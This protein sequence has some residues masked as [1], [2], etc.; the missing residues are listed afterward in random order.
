MKVKLAVKAQTLKLCPRGSDN[1]GL[2]QT[3]T[4]KAVKVQVTHLY[5]IR[6][7][8]VEVNL[9]EMTDLKSKGPLNLFQL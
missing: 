6:K 7:V 5:Q 8:Q 1:V 2:K 3:L 4:V 9:A